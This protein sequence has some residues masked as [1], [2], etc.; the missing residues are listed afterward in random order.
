[1]MSGMTFFLRDWNAKVSILVGTRDFKETVRRHHNVGRSV[2]WFL[3][4]L[5]RNV[6][7]ATPADLSPLAAG[8]QVQ[9]IDRQELAVASFSHVE[10]V[11]LFVMCSLEGR[12][13]IPYNFDMILEEYSR[14][15]H[16]EEDF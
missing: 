8:F 14:R 1:M 3:Q 13:W 2:R 6:G 15:L 10:L 5:L 12:G 9:C 11:V 16:L 7:K 4:A